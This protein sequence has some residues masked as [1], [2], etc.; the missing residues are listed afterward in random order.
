MILDCILTV[1]IFVALQ[2]LKARYPN[3]LFF[4]KG[5]ALFLPPNDTQEKPKKKKEKT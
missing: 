4:P 2:I 5:A 3:F 1:L